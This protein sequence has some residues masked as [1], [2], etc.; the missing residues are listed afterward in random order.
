[1]SGSIDVHTTYIFITMFIHTN[2]SCTWT[3]LR[4]ST[5][6]FAHSLYREFWT[7]YDSNGFISKCK[8]K[9]ACWKEEYLIL[10]LKGGK[11]WMQKPDSAENVFIVC[12]HWC[13]ATSSFV[14]FFGYFL[15]FEEFRCKGA[16]R[17]L[18]QSW[19]DGCSQMLSTR[20]ICSSNTFAS[21]PL[22]PTPLGH[23]EIPLF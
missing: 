2:L 10:E 8:L 9:E 3:S 6:V 5:I 20:T 14:L 12:E 17:H 18:C 23:S 1:M 22:N 19:D 13:C 4:I 15:A 16:K 7:W 11:L 21:N